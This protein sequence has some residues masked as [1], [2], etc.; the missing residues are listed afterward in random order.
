VAERMRV[1]VVGG[2]P[3]G[4]TAATA[5][6]Q[7]GLD[8]RLIESALFPRYH[9]GESLTPSCRAVLEAIGVAAKADA[10]GFVIKHGGV[11]WWDDE[12]WPGATP[13]PPSYWR[14]ARRRGSS[15]AGRRPPT[16][17]SASG[18]PVPR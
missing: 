18:C 7:A 2:G 8:V 17:S 10:Y 14:T 16:C 6:A 9:I 12:T 11:I 15:R 3:A 5:L 4:S 13:P 1:L